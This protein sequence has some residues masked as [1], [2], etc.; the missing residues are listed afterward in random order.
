MIHN[1]P[2]W[3]FHIKVISSAL[4]ILEAANNTSA[5]ADDFNASEAP[6]ALE[7]ARASLECLKQSLSRTD[8]IVPYQDD[9]RKLA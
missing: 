8:E 7:E 5:E 4:D 9:L 6:V 1:Q 2:N 3:K